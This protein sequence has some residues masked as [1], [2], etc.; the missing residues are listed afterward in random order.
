MDHTD[1]AGYRI[2]GGG[3]TDFFALDEYLAFI[4]GVIPEED[5]HQGRLARAVFAQQGA[6]LPRVQAEVKI[7]A[8]SNVQKSFGDTGHSHHRLLVINHCKKVQL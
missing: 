7:V 3:E 5:I 8:G 2:F 6:D 1:A 4:A